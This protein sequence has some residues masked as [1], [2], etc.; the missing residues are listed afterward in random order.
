LREICPPK[1]KTPKSGANIGAI[2]G[3][4]LKQRYTNSVV[5]IPQCNLYMQCAEVYTK[6]TTNNSHISSSC[7]CFVSVGL[8]EGVSIPGEDAP[9]VI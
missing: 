3:D 1:N 5:P 9:T 6:C 7:C 2:A 8:Q 4:L